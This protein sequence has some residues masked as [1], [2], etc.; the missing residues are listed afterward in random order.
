VVDI[1]DVQSGYAPLSRCRGH[2][3]TITNLDWSLPDFARGGKR[4]LQ[5]TCA[6]YELL[7]WDPLTGKQVLANQRDAV[8]ETYSC[9][10]GFSVMGI[11]PDG[12]DGTDINAVDRARVGQPFV[13]DKSDENSGTKS[14]SFPLGDAGL[15]HAGYVVTADD[16]GK[17]KLFNYP[18]VFND[19]PY[20][21]YKGHASHAMC[22]RFTCDDRRVIT[23]GG[24]DRAMLQF[25]TTGVRL[26]EPAPAYEPPPPETREWGPIDG[27]KAMGWI[28]PEPDEKETRRRE[29][30]K[31]AAPPRA[32]PAMT[33]FGEE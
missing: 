12:S 8:F 11:W 20:R 30:E 23:A 6:S 27:G 5:S 32:P 7:Y 13:T 19:A 17:I 28:E 18:C 33:G 31:R 2:Q 25:V 1:Y 10:L 29:E 24:R 15:E 26:D 22:A 4:V 16:F 14:V 21:E 3:A 9:A